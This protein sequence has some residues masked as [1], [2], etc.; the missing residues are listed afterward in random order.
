MAVL[1]LSGIGA[2]SLAYGHVVGQLV[3]LMLQY[4]RAGVPLRFGFV[5]SYARESAAFCLPLAVANLISWVLLSVDNVVVAR[6]LGSYELGLYV[7]AFN[8]SSW[9]MSAVG[10]SLRAV[11]LPAFARINNPGSRG[12]A[13]QRSAAVVW[14]L[15]LPMGV[16][17][18]T[19]AVPAVTLLYGERWRPAAT[20]MVGL[21]LFGSL[22]VVFDLFATFLV[23]VGATGRVLVVQMVWVVSMIPAMVLAVGR[24]GIAGAGWAHVLI[25]AAV[26]LPAYLVCLRSVGVASARI[27]AGC[28]L[29]TVAVLPLAASTWLAASLFESPVAALC[30]GTLLAVVLYVLPIGKWWIR[31]LR[32]LSRLE[33]ELIESERAQR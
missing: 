18:A 30:T 3:M 17:L 8:I 14:S 11:A 7:L 15:S 2:M 13:L 24:F 6:A 9:P 33:A 21:A 32:S 5:P 16:L 31:Q 19:L 25:S 1:A 4:R 22:R 29:P 28:A 27:L 12:S 23:S 10:Q 20:A 26:V